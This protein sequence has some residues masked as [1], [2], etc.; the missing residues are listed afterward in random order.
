M[1]AFEIKMLDHFISELTL[2]ED[3][4][5][6]SGLRFA[7]NI[8]LSY[9]VRYMVVSPH[10]SDDHLSTNILHVCCRCLF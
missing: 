7:L 8:K 10:D 3:V 9:I 6:T 5:H 4:K 2:D 1:R